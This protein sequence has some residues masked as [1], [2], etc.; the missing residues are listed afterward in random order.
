MDS[1]L[2]RCA[3]SHHLGGHGGSLDDLTQ[4]AALWCQKDPEAAVVLWAQRLAIEA[5][6]QSGNVGLRE[7][8]LPDFFSGARAATQATGGTTLIGEDTGRGWLLSGRLYGVPN[9]PW[10][11]FSLV[12]PV[13]LGPGNAGW[14]LLRSEEDGL[15]LHP[16]PEAPRFAQSSLQLNRVFFREDEWLGGPDM[17]DLLAPIGHALAPCRPCPPALKTL[18]T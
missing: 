3:V 1:G 15:S 11:G 17:A 13:R 2:L 9:L 6:V 5:L 8:W 4:A 10:E 14:V 18:A 12:A 16:E 7:L